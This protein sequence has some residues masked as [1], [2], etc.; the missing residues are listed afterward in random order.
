MRGGL[1]TNDGNL[2]HVWA[3]EGAG[4]VVKSIWDV[5]D[6]VDAG[7]LEVVLPQVRLPASPIHAIY[8]HG[9]LAAVKVRQCVNFL[10]AKM[11]HSLGA[12][13]GGETN[14]LDKENDEAES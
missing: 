2:A 7:R 6:D 11:K 10:A 12:S 13:V 4:L 8:P 3:L 14:T 1:I 5:R 9:R